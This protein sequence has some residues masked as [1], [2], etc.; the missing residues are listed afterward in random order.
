MNL[1]Y[2]IGLVIFLVLAAI[3]LVRFVNTTVDKEF[4]N[5]ARAV[6]D[7]EYR[8][9]ELRRVDALLAGVLPVPAHIKPVSSPSSF[10]KGAIA[11]VLLALGIILIWGGLTAQQDRSNWFY[12]GLACVALSSIIMLV[13]LRKRKWERVSRLLRFRADLK[14][15]DANPKGAASDLRELLK[16]TPWDDAAWAELSDDLAGVGQLQEAFD[17][18][19]QAARLDPRYD[20]YRL[21]EASLAIRLD[22]LDMARDALKAWTQLDGVR[23][24]DPRLAVYNAAIEMAA[25]DRDKAAERLR[26]VLTDHD[27][28]LEF[29]DTDQALRGLKDLLPGRTAL[30]AEEDSN[31]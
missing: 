15:L 9:G 10:G 13:T 11:P 1:Y 17:A 29:L 27:Q 21:L 22:K 5:L 28:P 8:D 23:D 2:A 19:R 14:R 31:G 7:D 25:G 18:I 4:R 20:E 26:S 6:S 3:L 30:A 12:G 16:L 24:D